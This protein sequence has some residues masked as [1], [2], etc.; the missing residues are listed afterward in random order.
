MKKVTL[1]FKSGNKIKFKCKELEFDYDKQ[2]VKRS[3]ILTS[4]TFEEWMFDLSQ[5]EAYIVKKCWF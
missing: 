1:Y 5:L 4:P 2:G 3:L